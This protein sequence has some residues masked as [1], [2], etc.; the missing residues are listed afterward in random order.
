MK[1]LFLKKIR[2][3]RLLFFIIL[4]SIVISIVFFDRKLCEYFVPGGSADQLRH[5]AGQWTH[6]GDAKYYFIFVLIF[7]GMIGLHRLSLKVSPFYFARYNQSSQNFKI[8]ISKM[9][10]FFINFFISLLYAGVLVH[11]LKFIFGRKRP[12]IEPFCQV[13]SFS[14]FSTQY[15]FHAFPSGHS[16]LI[17]SVV[18]FLSFYLPRPASLILFLF[19]AFIAFTRVMTRDHLLSDVIFGSFL[20]LFVS[21]WVHQNLNRNHFF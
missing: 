19:A 18:T 10:S 1:E 5:L 8:K 20:G 15:Q 9:E 16:Q 12:Y 21:H 4:S 14:F 13:D 6:V 11:L 2:N 17:W 7:L 3:Q